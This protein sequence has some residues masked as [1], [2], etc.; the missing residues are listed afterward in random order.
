MKRG[1]DALTE[2]WCKQARGLVR[3]ARN[4]NS[5]RDIVRLI[6]TAASLEH[7][8]RK[9]RAVANENSHEVAQI[10]RGVS[11]SGADR[12]LQSARHPTTGGCARQ[13]GPDTQATTLNQDVK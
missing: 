8:A 1:S 3:S 5:L 12:F 13:F 10:V 7:A 6:A 9:L 11:N 2:G 4:S